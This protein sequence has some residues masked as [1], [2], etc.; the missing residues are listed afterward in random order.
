MT[1]IVAIVSEYEIVVASDSQTTFGTSKRSDVDKISKV[2]FAD[3]AVALV[4]ESGSAQLSGKAIELLQ[5]KAKGRKLDDYRLV[6][7]LAE[8]S[9]REVRNS[10]IQ[11]NV[12]CDFTGDKWERYFRDE[13]PVELLLAYYFEDKPY[14]FT[15]DLNTCTSN[16]TTLH[17]EAVGCG[18]NLGGYLLGELSYQNMDPELATAIAVYVV[19]SVKKHDAYC[20]GATKVAVVRRKPKT[21]AGFPSAA[22]VPLSKIYSRREVEKMVEIVSEMDKK[23]KKQRHTIIQKALTK[24][25]TRQMRGMLLAEALS[26]YSHPRQLRID[27]ARRRVRGSVIP[28]QNPES[29]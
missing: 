23:T 21:W 4:A 8:E 14:I 26:R 19:E 1:I 17:Y 27:A 29:K 25:N 3:G 6:A 2:E 24:E 7:E 11:I 15:V 22:D 18:A 13:Y 28:Q 20:G 5:R 16:K 9:L 12:G 10:Q